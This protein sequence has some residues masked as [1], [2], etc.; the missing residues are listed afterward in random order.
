ML[1]AVTQAF[2]DKDYAISK[3][4]SGVKPLTDEIALHIA[5]NV[6]AYGEVLAPLSDSTWERSCTQWMGDHWELIV[7]LCTESEGVSDLAL[8]GRMYEAD[9][10]YS[11]EVSTVHV[12]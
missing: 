12:P 4:I 7:D 10:N 2:V 9:G 5:D 1:V 11:L 3:N 6:S 8:H